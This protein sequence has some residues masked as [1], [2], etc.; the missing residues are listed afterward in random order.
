MCGRYTLVTGWDQLAEEFDLVHVEELR[1]RF[2]IAPTQVVPVVRVHSERGVRRLDALRWGLIPFWAKDSGIG[3]RMINARSE[4]AADKPSFRTPLRQRRC[5]V[6]CSGFYEWK[7]LDTDASRTKSRKQP[8][9]IRRRDERVFAFA[10]LWDRWRGSDGAAIESFS[11]LTTEPNELIRPFHNRMPVILGREDYDLWLDPDVQ[12]VG[13][14]Q[15]LFRP[16]PLDE[17][18]VF[19]VGTRVNSPSNDDPSCVQPAP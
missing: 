4:E 3:S 1:P 7:A 6:P 18:T 12:N 9:Y 2:N 17:L 14:L 16:F 15:R 13:R 8:Y 10:G 11:I 19:P 5:L